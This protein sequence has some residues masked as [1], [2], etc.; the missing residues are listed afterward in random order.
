MQSIASLIF[1]ENW[2]NKSF[3]GTQIW[4][5]RLDAERIVMEALDKVVLLDKAD[6]NPK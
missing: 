6:V 2:E 3:R 4:I 1:G 5:E